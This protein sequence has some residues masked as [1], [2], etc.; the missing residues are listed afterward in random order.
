M[1]FNSEQSALLR[2][3]DP[4]IDLTNELSDDFLLES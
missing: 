4:N 3:I 2:K 1:K